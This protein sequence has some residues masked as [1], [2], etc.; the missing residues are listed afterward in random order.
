MEVPQTV[1]EVINALTREMRFDAE[2]SLK[3]GQT[4][5][6]VNSRLNFT[7]GG[8]ALD[9]VR[10]ELEASGNGVA[11]P[12]AMEVDNDTAEQVL[13]TPCMEVDVGLPN[14]LGAWLGFFP[15]PCHW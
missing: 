13:V 12:E 7:I 14:V 3:L 8:K 1:W 4:L 10:Q 2:T 9:E 5:Q 11:S 15:G 6:N